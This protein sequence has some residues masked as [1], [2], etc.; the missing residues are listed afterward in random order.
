MSRR[1]SIQRLLSVAFTLG[2]LASHPVFAANDAAPTSSPATSASCGTT[3]AE[4]IAA[5]RKALAASDA[6]SERAAL[7][8][9]IEAVS[10]IDAK[11][12]IAS[13][14]GGNVLAVPQT[15]NGAKP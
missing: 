12:P 6:R 2:L 11:S 7:A 10:A 3:T 13:R 4:Q 8:C 15:S 1:D 9:L 14:P 5:A